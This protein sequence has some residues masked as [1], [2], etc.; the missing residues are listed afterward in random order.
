MTEAAEH[1]CTLAI[2]ILRFFN[3]EIGS[4]S[5]EHAELKGARKKAFSVE[6]QTWVFALSAVHLR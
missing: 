5:E 3:Q 4:Q 2:V 6:L 1:V